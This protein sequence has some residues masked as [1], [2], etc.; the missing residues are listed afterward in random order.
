L[1]WL[2]RTPLASARWIVID[3]ETSGLDMRKDRLLSVAAVEV[4]HER[5]VADRSYYAVVRQ[6]QPSAVDN[7]LVHGLGAATQ[8]E[9]RPAA[10]VL[11][12]LGTFMDESLPV[13][14]HAPFDQAM[15]ERA[16]AHA[17]IESRRKRWLDLAALGPVLFPDRTA[18]DLDSWLAGFGIEC[19]ARH[20]ALSDAYS[21]A[22]LLLVMLRKALQDGIAT[23][24]ALHRLAA[25][26]HWLPRSR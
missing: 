24:E 12:E 7:I 1:S 21:T 16:V 5:I 15:I 9:G 22:Q 2:R 26:R 23:V 14:F 3:C 18:N 25:S 13:A 4:A 19:D 11:R 8:L 17:G 20:D 10:E 6:E